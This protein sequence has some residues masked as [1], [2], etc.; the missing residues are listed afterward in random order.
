MTMKFIIVKDAVKALLENAA[1]GRYGVAGAQKQEKGTAAYIGSNRLVE[2]YFRTENFSKSKGRFT[3]P[4]NSDVKIAIELTVSGPVKADLAILDD[5][6]GS[7]AIQLQTAI[8]EIKEASSVADD[9]MDEL[10]DIV[11]QIIMDAKNVDLGLAEGIV[12]DRWISTLDK[13]D[14]NPRG[15]LVVL[16][17]MLEFSCN[18][19]EDVPG[20]IGEP[21]T[22]NDIEIE[23]NND[24]VQ[25]TGAI[26]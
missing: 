23:I 14:P 16:T 7:T 15:Q 1:A 12:A 22:T 9:S 3:G 25:K 19:E 17:G 21:Y 11:Y 2:V 4:N 26:V 20:D 10:F 18:V 6:T 24:T 5:P 13:S 8:A